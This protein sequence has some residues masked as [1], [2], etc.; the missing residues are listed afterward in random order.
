[1]SIPSVPP[2]PGIPTPTLLTYADLV[3][4]NMDESNDV[5]MADTG[6]YGHRVQVTLGKTLFNLY[7]RW[8]RNVGQDRPHAKLSTSDVI[9]NT[10]KSV[11][12]ESLNSSYMD[13]DGVTGG[14][15]FS[16]ANLSLNNDPRLRKNGLVSA[17]DI[18]MAF[19]MYRLYGNSAFSTKN[20]V[21]NLQDAHD[22]L[23]SETVADA[24][25][26]SFKEHETGALDKMFRDLLSQDPRRFFDENGHQEPNLFET[27]TDL[28]GD[29]SWK[30]I[31]N[32]VVEI[33]T[34]LIFHSNVTKRGVAGREHLLSDVNEAENQ[35]KIIV[36]D[37]YFY[38]RLQLKIVDDG[39]I[40][41]PTNL[42][43][44]DSTKTVVTGY[45]GSITGELIIPEGATS[46]ATGAFKN[47]L[48]LTSVLFPQSLTSI[49][50]EAFMNT[51]LVEVFLPNVTSIGASGFKNS[52]ALST[53]LAPNLTSI[54]ANA[55][56]G[57]TALES[58]NGTSSIPGGAR[59][60]GDIPGII[61]TNPIVNLTNITSLGAST[62]TGCT[63]IQDVTIPITF[64]ALPAGVFSG[65]TNIT[66]IIIPTSVTSLGASAFAGTGL[67]SITLHSGLTVYGTSV[68]SGCASLASVTLMAPI[69]T[70]P[71]G[72]FLNCS[73]ITSVTLPSSLLTI[74]AQ[75]LQN[76]RITT[77]TLP[78]VVTISSGAFAQ[79]PA[80]LSV[81]A[82]S[83]VNVASD[84]F[85]GS[86]NVTSAPADMSSLTYS[87]E[88]QT[89]VTGYTGSFGIL[90]FPA[91][92]TAIADSAFL[93]NS[94][95]IGVTIPSTLQ[96]IGSSAF[97]G[98]GLKSITLP[99][100][101]T[102]VGNNAF[103]NC[104]GLTSIA[105]PG[106][107][108]A[109][110]G[111]FLF[112]GCT[113]LTSVTVPSGMTS[114]P[115]SC[116]NSCT[117]LASV[118]LHDGVSSI[119]SYA[120]SA[121]T[122]ISSFTIPAG[123]TTLSSY[124]F[125]GC[126][127][128]T[129]ITLPST[130]MNYQAGV[131][132]GCTGL[133]SIVF[134]S[135]TTTLIGDQA[136]GG[137]TGLTSV[138]FPNKGSS[139][140]FPLTLG[141]SVLL[142]CS[143]LTSF[144][145]PDQWPSLPN[146]FFENCSG[147]TSIE[148]PSTITSMGT[149]VFKGCSGL[150]SA[151]VNAAISALPVSTFLNCTSLASILL[152][153]SIITI[154][155][156]ALR[157]TRLTTFVNFA[158]KTI[159][160]L[161]FADNPTISS[162]NIPNL[163]TLDATAFNNTPALL[164]KPQALVRSGVGSVPVDASGNM[165]EFGY[166]MTPFNTDDSVTQIPALELQGF[167]FNINGTNYGTSI[168]AS[169]NLNITFGSG[170]ASGST[171]S[172]TS[173]RIGFALASRDSRSN[174]IRYF[175]STLSDFDIVTLQYWFEN[176]YLDITG[177]TGST[178]S[179]APGSVYPSSAGQY[180]IRLIKQL[181]N[182]KQWVE[183]RIVK[184]SGITTDG[185]WAI[186]RGG[187]LTNASSTISVTAA[188]TFATPATILYSSD[189]TGTSWT[190]EKNKFV[191]IN[192]DNSVVNAT[193]LIAT[194]AAPLVIGAGTV[195]LTSDN[196]TPTGYGILTTPTD[197]S[198]IAVPGAELLGFTFNINGVN[199]G[200]SIFA[201]TNLNITLGTAASSTTYSL[202]ST[203]RGFSFNGFNS[204]AN[205]INYFRSSVTDYEILTFQYWFENTNT[206]TS[207]VTDFNLSDGQLQVRLINRV[208]TGTQFVEIRTVKGI[209]IT[210]QG[211]WVFANTTSVNSF[212]GYITTT[213]ATTFATPATIVYVSDASGANWQVAKGA[214]VD[215]NNDNSVVTPIIGIAPITSPLVAGT[216]SV[217]ITGG[218][219]NELGTMVLGLP[220]DTGLVY[221]PY[222]DLEGFTFNINGVDRGK[223]IRMNT[224]LIIGFNDSIAA[225][226]ITP[227]STHTAVYTCAVDTK[228]N[229]ARYFRTTIAGQY[230]IVTI[231]FWAENIYTASIGST[232]ISSSPLQI[233][234][235]LIK[236]LVTNIQYIETR[237]LK[238]TPASIFC[239]IL[240]GVYVI[241]MASYFDASVATTLTTPSSFVF[242][243]EPTGTTWKVVKGAYVDV[244][245]THSIINN[246][247]IPADLIAGTGNVPVINGNMTPSGILLNTTA[248]VISTLYLITPTSFT[249]NFSGIDC[250][251]TISANANL[252]IGIGSGNG[253][254]STTFTSLSPSYRAFYFG[255]R[256]SRTNR[257]AWSQ[258]TDSNYNIVS[259][260]YYF[261]NTSTGT[262]GNFNA[263]MASSGQARIR[264]IKNTVTGLQYV[265]M[266]IVRGMNA[267]AI[268]TL[269]Y[270]NLTYGNS[271]IQQQ[272]AALHLGLAAPA[273]A[274]TINPW[275]Q[276]TAITWASDPTGSFWTPLYNYY[277]NV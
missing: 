135:V 57:C 214:Y 113:G 219:M 62:F 275:A 11:L 244:N 163:D 222:L 86:S 88:T 174:R 56:E 217:P 114:I 43:Y 120:F 77:I 3:T 255:S 47:Q 124:T 262:S 191:N 168:Y 205:R 208:S 89:T 97:K 73:S 233:Q 30:L 192:N 159:N 160:A 200:T 103:Q 257:I 277:V 276:N 54:G 182:G 64:T 42:I 82:P 213:P 122:S 68:F 67:T 239:Q 261:E 142:G 118:T 246:R 248:S 137:C 16:T 201:S 221:V 10:F 90:R 197:D 172:L 215:V 225:A 38:I 53:V 33:K 187:T 145:I 94:N 119:G 9:E 100:T 40:V 21:F 270:F 216:G 260:Q 269:G 256:S 240:N 126:T 109:S 6:D 226:T 156:Q 154:D 108:I 35:Q 202:A 55:F 180:Q 148:V 110:L 66:S 85:T 179:Y 220:S 251:G 95:V 51:G 63:S 101:L 91:S 104:A 29:G 153:S 190:I 243:S 253:V 184:G 164:E 264:F 171:Y 227:L 31:E 133:T 132:N 52:T 134:P 234:V 265:E 79:N 238:G 138:T 196:M 245:N 125:N 69:L 203:N 131:F 273:T 17:N 32:D 209:N 58:L 140:M 242:A 152:A 121:C 223:N 112:A 60:V 193:N 4:V 74:A 185:Q 48:G 49:G 141:T 176:N 45:T 266:C 181:S 230:D 263:P 161:A 228:T 37:D 254:L 232:T 127:G 12:I 218:N 236:D 18:P 206:G 87:D 237:T 271:G 147:L 178:N 267:T 99:S 175:R 26:A 146:G 75:A 158:V 151:M 34:K 22:M 165:I 46:I 24:I 23:T 7:F 83:A 241:D 139:G 36:P 28:A 173:T 268:A 210:T 76:T 128:L 166:N 70:L 81:I 107:N 224:N 80:L 123:L 115:A 106:A 72:I 61:Q 177:N 150:T 249:F 111:N 44:S 27:A 199:Y 157:N 198:V 98:S 186:A 211:D 189:L 274:V 93:N 41:D 169:T 25:I 144:T 15:H 155:T 258:S 13:I 117:T 194:I 252:V 39:T 20:Y 71:S 8:R 129:A 14:L 143:G 105:F 1:M 84:A 162:T 116:F 229:R 65:C 272:N 102:S 204:K 59:G 247:I 259:I 5:N 207:G 96:T 250:G 170:L 231:Q 92:V 19:V 183:T 149:G 136:L 130:L 235:R 188:T 195:P 50:T 78:N 212:S 2:I 167:T